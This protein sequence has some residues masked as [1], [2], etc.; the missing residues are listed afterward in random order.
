[1]TPA[2]RCAGR[3]GLSLRASRGRKSGLR[4]CRPHKGKDAVVLTFQKRPDRAPP[5]RLERSPY[6]SNLKRASAVGGVGD[7]LPRMRRSVRRQRSLPGA[8]SGT[9]PPSAVGLPQLRLDL[10]QHRRTAER[11]TH[12]TPVVQLRRPTAFDGLPTRLTTWPSRPSVPMAR[13]RDA[14]GGLS[15]FW[16]PPRTSGARLPNSRA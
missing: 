5:S 7:R 14:G 9:R 4:P 3:P 11:V 12:A 2:T 10:D 13:E 8:N 6:P 15:R 16:R 1:V